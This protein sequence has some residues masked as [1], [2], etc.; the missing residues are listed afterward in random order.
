MK[1]I[2]I[3]QTAFIGDVILTLPLIEAVHRKYPGSH[4]S[5]M[6][7]PKAYDLVKANPYINEV[8]VYD[9]NGMDKGFKN[10][11][12]FDR[13]IKN[14][15]YD[16]AILPHRSVRSVMLAYSGGIP[17][18]IGFDRSAAKIFLTKLVKYSWDKHEVERNLSLIDEKNGSR[19]IPIFLGTGDIKKAGIFLKE[20]GVIKKDLIIG[21]A[22]GSVWAT[23]RW[24][25]ERFAELSE[26]LIDVYGSKII[27]IGG[28]EDE[29]LCNEIKK[30]TGK[31]III[32]AGALSLGESASVISKCDLFITNDTAPLH[33][34][35]AFQVPTVAIFGPTTTGLGFGPYSMKNIVVE[36][37]LS[38]R[39]CGRHGHKVCPKEHF[40]CMREITVDEVFDA[41]RR[42]L[43]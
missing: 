27:L 9:K 10:F 14:Q 5:I 17:E 2:L 35:S 37:I 3:I 43:K 18:R 20:Q 4:I 26:R 19:H 32:A 12:K 6:I 21:L 42:L 15:K 41:C 31:E 34:A 36:K 28:K 23:K 22:P 1:K 29:E 11:V 13:K 8:I 24:I 38:C 40:K 16:M 39:P 25:K 7:T 33:L 30:I